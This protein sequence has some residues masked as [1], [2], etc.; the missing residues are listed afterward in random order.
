MISQIKSFVTSHHTI[1]SDLVSTSCTSTGMRVFFIILH[2]FPGEQDFYIYIYISCFLLLLCCA[3]FWGT[4]LVPVTDKKSPPSE[5]CYEYK[6]IKILFFLQS[7]NYIGPSQD[8]LKNVGNRKGV[9]SRQANSKG[10]F[11]KVNVK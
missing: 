5:S 3:D 1:L 9:E 6:C 7:I 4:L 8:V 2:S 10:V 11:W